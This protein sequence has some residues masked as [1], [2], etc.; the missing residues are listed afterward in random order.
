MTTTM[1]DS[2]DQ[3]SSLKPLSLVS[4]KQ[5]K[6]HVK[7][8]GY[9][10]KKKQTKKT[11]LWNHFIQNSPEIQTFSKEPSCRRKKP[12]KNCSTD[13][14]FLPINKSDCDNRSW[15]YDNTNWS[16]ESCHYL[17]MELSA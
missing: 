1:A 10:I 16:I 7:D 8:Y 14:D 5:R 3:K 4:W 2:F 11:S 17:P 15:V 13:D 6:L 12:H 9:S